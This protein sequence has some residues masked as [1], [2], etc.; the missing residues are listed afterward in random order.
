MPFNTNIDMQTEKGPVR[1]N[2]EDSMDFLEQPNTQDGIAAVYVVAD[3][4]GGHEKGEIASSM[5]VELLIKACSNSADEPLFPDSNRSFESYLS[6]LLLKINQEVCRVGLTGESMHRNPDRPGMATTLTAAILI[7][8]TVY[9]G[10]V[11]DSRAYLLRNK[12]IIQI[13]NDDTLVA[14]H[15]RKGTLTIQQASLYPSNV[16]TQAIGLDQPITPFTTR[17]SIVDND[18]VLLCTDGLHGFLDDKDILATIQKHPNQVAISLLDAAIAGGS[19]DNITTL[20]IR[21]TST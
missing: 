18:Q 14:E 20:L 1:E 3:G 5:A 4:L 10:H 9:I 7:G 11:G 8:G 21:F 2:N 15:I 16:L 13:T 19:N 6:D 17:L 12:Q